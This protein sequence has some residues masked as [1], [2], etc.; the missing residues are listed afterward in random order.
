M[1][2]INKLKG[3]IVEKGLNITTLSEKMNIDKSTFYRKLERHG[4]A[5]TIKEANSI[6]EILGL[7]GLEMTEIFF[8]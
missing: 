3:K 1:P 4:E 8:N 7:S 2:N 5:F 6:M